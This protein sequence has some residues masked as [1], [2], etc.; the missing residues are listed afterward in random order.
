MK[1]RSEWLGLAALAGVAAYIIAFELG[2]SRWAIS[3]PAHDVYAYFYP[4]MLY[5]LQSLQRG[6][7]GLL[8]NP[9]QNCGQPFFANSQ[10]GLLYPANALF[11]VLGP[12]AALR[13]VLLVNLLVAGISTYLLCREIGAGPLAACAGALAF[14]LGN[15][16]LDLTVWGPTMAGPYVWLPAGMLFCERILRAP[17]ARNAA[18][19]GVVFALAVLPGYVQPVFL[20][21]QLIGLRVLW[22]LASRRV[23]RPAAALLT[24]GAGLALPF[25][26]SAVQ[27]VPAAEVARESVRSMSLS[28]AEMNPAGLLDWQRFRQAVDLRTP[29]NPLVL[30]PC[31]LVG[32][33]LSERKTRP[34]AL[35][36]LIA[37]VLCFVL[38]FGPNTPLFRLYMKLP[39]AG[40]FRYAE[41]F[42]WLTSFSLAIL[43]A[44]GLE[45]VVTTGDARSPGA[46]F[47]GVAA[48]VVALAAFRLLTP[49]GLRPLEWPVA[50]LAVAAC[51][52]AAASPGLRRWGGAAV[53]VA[54]LA[55]VLAVPALARRQCLLADGEQLFTH[56]ATFGALRE[57][58]TPQDRAYF[59]F[60]HPFG[61]G[62]RLILKSASLFDV[63][64]IGDYEPQM[65]R[66]YA[67]YSVMMR[68]GRPMASLNDVLYVNSW[69]P[70]G[71]NRRL[72][73]LSAVRYLLVDPAVD[74]T[75]AVMQPPLVPVSG[76][77]A[78][79]SA[80]TDA[81]VRLYEN[82]H[83]LPRAFYVPRVAVVTDSSALLE[84]LAR[85][86][87]DPRRV[88]LVE[89]PPPTGFTGSP[90]NDGTGSVTFETD[91][92]EHVVL[93]VHA[94]RRG[95]LFLA[96][97]H[98]PG[99]R[100]TV[101]GTPT[102][103]LR[104]NY[105]FRLVEVPAGDST[106]E[107]RYAPTSIR[108]GTCVS[109]V[110]ILAVGILLLRWA[111][112][113]MGANA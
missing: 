108:L 43:M 102:P 30:V 36:Y 66:R 6:G 24:L 111:P 20:A 53:V 84:R 107:F 61:T 29:S 35:F 78:G 76:F 113:S 41:R 42:M 44:L 51:A 32:A 55:N 112:G 60:R 49:K 27:L 73:D 110:T 2:P 9:F 21:Y 77:A 19:L 86:R 88:A 91:D 64:T 90:N 31:L 17:S 14:E 58:M 99:W 105:T 62:F 10:T 37:G 63:P 74:N 94:A 70:P 3:L 45:A 82:P 69:T 25:L 40:L 28:A 79:A 92:P 83:A 100:A 68:L 11:L 89:V 1:A 75:A 95:F 57:R 48:A 103:I 85:G 80:G 26:L 98:F 23:A 97:T 46:A 67:E 71:L 106:V 18:G 65:S 52:A 59:I 12:D 72:L 8:W 109:G 13:G 16:T 47:A 56:A 34:L 104:A 4:N 39:V 96:D 38:A 54:L 7:R 5:A 33:A 22:A 101:G 87:D 81:D 15:S 93:R 50:A